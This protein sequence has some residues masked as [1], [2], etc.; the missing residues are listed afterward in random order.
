MLHVEKS[1]IIRKAP[2]VGTIQ[3]WPIHNAMTDHEAVK[4]ELQRT[5]FKE[6]VSTL[7][8]IYSAAETIRAD[9]AAAASGIE[10]LTTEIDDNEFRTK[11]V[12]KCE[13]GHH[14]E[15]LFAATHQLIETTDAAA[16]THL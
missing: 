14:R 1:P 11:S 8:E 7:G 6:T 3:S 2:Y 9:F 15:H 13:V 12:G 4:P 10:F 5:L 16:D